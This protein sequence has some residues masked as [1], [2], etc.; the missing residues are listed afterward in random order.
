MK[1]NAQNKNKNPAEHLRGFL[2]LKNDYKGMRLIDDETYNALVRILAQDPKIAVFQK[3]V[4]SKKV[5]E[6]QII[7]EE[8]REEK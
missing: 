6:N 4:L 7:E 5:E 8:T 1:K 2:L 3:L